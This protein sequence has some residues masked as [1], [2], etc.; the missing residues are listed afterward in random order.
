MTALAAV[1]MASPAAAIDYSFGEVTGS[2][3]T[4]VTAGASMRTSARDCR[5]ISLP[6]GGCKVFDSSNI[7][8]GNGLNTDDGNLNYGQWDVF[9]GALKAT[10]ETGATWRNFNAFVRGT[11]FVDPIVDNTDFRDLESGARSEVSQ[12]AKLLDYFVGG[13]FDLGG[14][15]LEL[16]GGNQ[17]IS[18][19]ESTFIQNGINV[20]NPIDVAAVR[21]PGSE[22]KEFFTPV[23]AAKA[24]LGLPNNFSVE[25]FYQFKSDNIVPDPSGTF[26]SGAD[27]VGRGSQPIRAGAF[28][29]G[30]DGRFNPQPVID[31]LATSGTSVFNISRLA[32]NLPA[33]SIERANDVNAD[34]GGE[35]GFALRYFNEELNNGTEFG[36]FFINYHS[37]LPVLTTNMTDPARAIS[38]V[39]GTTFSGFGRDAFDK[40]N[41]NGTV[42]ADAT[43]IG[44]LDQSNFNAAVAALALAPGTPG[45]SAD[46]GIA[47][48]R[49]PRLA[50]TGAA[51]SAAGGPTGQNEVELAQQLCNAA[52]AATGPQMQAMGIAS[53]TGRPWIAGDAARNRANV[54]FQTPGGYTNCLN[55]GRVRALTGNIAGSTA[56]TLANTQNFR[57]EYP[58][59][60]KLVGASLSTTLGSLAFQAEATYR[61]DQP[62]SY[63][64]SE[65]AALSA[66]LDGRTAL[67]TGADLPAGVGGKYVGGVYT[68]TNSAPAQ[69]LE[70]V[71]ARFS[72][73]RVQ[74]F[75]QVATGVTSIANTNLVNFA[76]AALIEGAQ[77]GVA[78]VYSALPNPTYAAGALTTPGLAAAADLAARGAL[79]IAA[80]PISMFVPSTLVNGA[81]VATSVL[82]GTGSPTSATNNPAANGV[83]NPNPGVF[84]PPGGLGNLAGIDGL[85]IG[86]PPAV[87]AANPA[88]TTTI[89][90]PQGTAASLVKV[91][92]ERG[93]IPLEVLGTSN[94]PNIPVAMAGDQ[95]FA[96]HSDVGTGAVPLPITPQ[97]R[98]SVLSAA[99]VRRNG[100]VEIPKEDVFTAQGTITSVLFGSNPIVQFA[101]ADGGAV[102]TEIGMVWAPG[103]STSS[104]LAARGSEGLLN[105]IAA[106]TYTLNADLKGP[107]NWATP[108]SWGAQG[109]FNMT[110]NRV[111]GSPVN[112]VPQIAW[113]WDLGGRTPAPLGNYMAES[114]AIGLSLAANYQ[115]RWTGSMSWTANFGPDAPLD[116]RDFAS[117]NIAYAF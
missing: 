72:S 95:L 52:I 7:E 47:G 86:T 102:V 105:P 60:I 76:T 35:F 117:I 113:R 13:S 10:S 41:T 56:A 101:S 92:N 115:S 32:V 23:L 15:P 20:I 68:A 37:R 21:K 112:L 44:A 100:Y 3:D 110:Y 8:K 50:G 6:A 83:S 53:A 66:D 36:L 108:F 48:L 97:T 9:S 89:I 114:K 4:V 65:V 34:D 57:L 73:T 63:V 84:G 70:I 28:N 40:R 107:T 103:I 51:Y 22:V 61:H 43:T 75:H 1:F 62:M 14:L 79:T 69:N 88:G 90:F 87:S 38:I 46:S 109:I 18:W 93:F 85:T 31:G 11:A 96:R 54:D 91:A 74:N 104:A 111:F 45:A 49:A 98:S 80:L 24:S 42:Q 33:V 64:G 39:T 116:D 81:A 5:N 29:A 99:N 30:D 58:E 27:I 59:D 67:I 17:V 19:G 78:G 94:A 12:N 26:F 106:A 25:G 16:R 82:A 71:P 77:A 2:I 55:A